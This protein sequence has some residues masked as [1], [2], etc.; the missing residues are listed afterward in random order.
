MMITITGVLL[1][2]VITANKK[3]KACQVYLSL[4][5]YLIKFNIRLSVVFFL[6][7]PLLIVDNILPCSRGIYFRLFLL[8]NRAHSIVKE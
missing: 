4:N 6:G 5:M 7:V 3:R 8:V 2:T 1:I